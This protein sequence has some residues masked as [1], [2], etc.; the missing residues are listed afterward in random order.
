M[1]LSL[2]TIDNLIAAKEADSAPDW[3]ARGHPFY[4]PLPGVV[5]AGM[6]TN[7]GSEEVETSTLN[8]KGWEA[9]VYQF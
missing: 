4:E 5:F 7:L 3:P 6:M 8:L 2:R 9:G 1:G